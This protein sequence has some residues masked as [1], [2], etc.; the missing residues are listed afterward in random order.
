M[1]LKMAS[2]RDLPALVEFRRSVFVDELGVQQINYQDVF[3]DFF[4]KNLIVIEGD[5]LL[6]AVRVAFHRETQRFYISYLAIRTDERAKLV[7][8]LL[9]GGAL[10]VLRVNGVRY[11]FVDSRAELTDLYRRFGCRQCGPTLV[12]Y[13]FTCEWVPMLFDMDQTSDLHAWLIQRVEPF[14]SVDECRWEFAPEIQPCRD[15]VEYRRCLARLIASRQIFG[16]FPVIKRGPWAGP[17]ESAGADLTDDEAEPGSDAFLRINASLQSR[18]VIVAERPSPAHAAAAC[19]ATLTGKKL[20]I[21]DGIERFEPD[22]TT[23]SVLLMGV[24]G[25]WT[26]ASLAR[27]F[28]RVGQRTVGIMLWRDLAAASQHVVRSYVLFASPVA[29]EAGLASTAMIMSPF[30]PARRDSARRLRIVIAS[31]RATHCILA[32]ADLA[33]SDA[34]RARCRNLLSAGHSFGETAKM[35]NDELAPY[36][37]VPHFVVYGDPTLQVAQRAVAGVTA[38]EPLSRLETE[39]ESVHVVARNGPTTQGRAGSMHEVSA[40]AF[41][42]VLQG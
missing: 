17:A 32:P 6:G 22:A 27:F 13:G 21:A 24:P 25:D 40:E 5:R 11:A 8:A 31:Y 42:A 9:L 12:K 1:L 2:G 34:A 33:D 29:R 23:Q 3:N 15:A 4:S 16:T 26:S 39:L 19:Y 38:V 28:E 18:H 35:L 37:A 30:A 36:A 14:L 20:L 41:N 7:G 10:R